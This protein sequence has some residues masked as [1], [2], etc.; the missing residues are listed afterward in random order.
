MKKT[1]LLLTM[2]LFFFIITAFQC[3]DCRS[4]TASIGR[5]RSWFPLKG[6]TQLSFRDNT[7][8]VTNF[9]LNVTDT[10][11]TSLNECGTPIKYEYIVTTLY[12][13]QN[14]TDSI[15]FSLSSGG[16][17][18]M[19]ARSNDSVNVSMCN[20][21]GQTA[22]A[23]VAKK[24]TNYTAGTKTYPEA[25]LLLSDPL[26]NKNIDSI[27]IANQAGIVGFNYANKKYTLL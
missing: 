20:V 26:Y 11:E 3:N 25:I 9:K 18:C 15:Y 10:T 4:G 19:R 2:L 5:T 8:S 27:I 1:T 24:L 13:D 17:L 12:L 21:F 16:W 14:S 23:R 22:E 6:K 7:A